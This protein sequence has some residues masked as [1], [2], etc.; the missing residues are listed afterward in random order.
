MT[1]EQIESKKEHAGEKKASMKRRDDHHD[2]TERRMYMITMEV[3]GRRPLFGRIVGDALAPKGSK[4]EPHIELSDI[5]KAFES[6]WFGIHGYYP[7]IEVVAVQMMPD[8]LHGIL[9][10]R[11]R[12]P[13]HLGQVISGFKAGCRKA[14]RA[15]R[16]GFAAAKPQPTE[17]A[18]ENLAAAEPQPTEKGG[19]NF[20]AAEPQP[21]EKGR[22]NLAAAEAQATEKAE[23]QTTEKAEPQA[24]EKGRANFAAAKPQPTEKGGAEGSRQVTALPSQEAYSPLFAK[25]YND[26]ILRSYEELQTWLNYLRENPRRLMMKRAR[27]EWLRPFFNLM[28]GQHTYS[29][30]GNRE[31]LVAAKRKAV[32]VSR[33]LSEGQIAKEVEHY[34]EEAQKG[35]V[36]V[37]PAISPGEKRV[38]RAVFDAGFPI[39]VISENGF[40]PLSKPHGEQFYACAKGLL[41]MLSP[42]EHHND[43]RKL[44]ALQCS[45]MNLMALEICEPNIA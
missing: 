7:Q 13:V 19:E 8:H 37:S 39:I 45:Q 44:T 31:L 14:E 9:F 18:G 26:L 22:A 35:C 23:P 2:Y 30:V 34:L 11:D 28:I 33:R 5:G 36:L 1:E 25:G 20:A 32:R 17:K 27:P 15:L 21:T 12:L 38:M 24:T 41:L 40:T 10:V 6:E 4:N 3:E 29:G 42:W 16:G 43:K